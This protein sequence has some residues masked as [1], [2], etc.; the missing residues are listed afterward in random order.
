AA[1]TMAEINLKFIWDVISQIRV[2]TKG[3][4]FVVDTRGLL[5]ADPDIGLVLRKTDLSGSPLV[6]QV[7]AA[8]EKSG[9]VHAGGAEPLL[10]GFATIDSLG[11]KVLAQEPTSEVYAYLNALIKGSLA[12]LLAGLVV[13]AL[14]ALVFTRRMV[15]PIRT[16]QQGA[17][18]IAEG[19]LGARIEVKTGDELEALAG[20]FNRMSS[21]LE[22]SYADLER[23]VEERTS[24]LTET[25]AQQTATADILRVISGSPTDL[26]PVLDAIAGRAER[27]CDGG[28][29]V[30]YLCE[31][32]VMRRA[33]WHGPLV[34]G[35]AGTQPL[36]TLSV[37]GRAVCE[38]ATI[39][40]VDLAKER[41]RYPL[42]W[43]VLQKL[44]ESNGLSEN[45]S[46]I[47][48]PLLKEGEAVGAIMVRRAE[49]RAFDDKQVMLLRTFADQAVIA[50]ENVR[51]FNEIQDK[52]RQL[53]AANKHKSEFLANMSHELRTP[54]NAIIGFSEVL[55][56]PMFG[57]LN[58]EQ[59]E[60]IRDIH[61]SGK[62]LLA[63]INDILDLSKVE[64]G[65]MELLV[66]ELDLPSAI[67][68]A[69]TLVKERASRHRIRLDSNLDPSLG[70][71]R[72]DERKLKQI[73]LNLL[74]NAV[75][76]TPEGGAVKVS[77]RAVQGGTEIAVADTGV[78]IAPADHEAV[79]EEFRQ[80]GKDIL[81]KAE[82]TGLGLGLARRF[83][84]L[85]GGSIRLASELGKGST[86]TLFL[87][88]AAPPPS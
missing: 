35:G 76:F 33:A 51:L 59:A 21:R 25:L 63:L 80:V 61:E 84:E 8:N 43:E 40:V 29:A 49:V 5:V 19:E 32:D 6:S 16:L 44:S 68:N 50:I 65:R 77:A 9:A 53:E 4:A 28:S 7:L 27:L 60:F 34:L 45:H 23:K 70:V 72:A 62:H 73:L 88:D 31:G 75:K 71:I 38:K 83:A 86:F 54:L 66:E 67:S 55:Q 26:Q 42:S 46:M 20:E 22:E 69:L 36:S 17:A 78:G 85:H 10:A 56:E 58:E 74:S 57:V 13:S 37:I 41:D 2:G 11:W 30:V 12:V 3:K 47:A 39:Q 79:F 15:R 14:A 87:P 24:E 52:G 1:L 81:R 64:A 18:R 82:G 48:V